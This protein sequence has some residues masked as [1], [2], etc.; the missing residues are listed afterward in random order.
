MFSRYQFH[1]LADACIEQKKTCTFLD[2]MRCCTSRSSAPDS[3]IP[4]SEAKLH[5]IVRFSNTVP[6]TKRPSKIAIKPS[7]RSGTSDPL[8]IKATGRGHTVF[9]VGPHDALR[10]VAVHGEGRF[11]PRLG[12]FPAKS[13][14]VTENSTSAVKNV[15]PMVALMCIQKERAYRA[16]KFD[17][18]TLPALGPG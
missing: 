14:C 2:E 10:R 3:R 6:C 9:H 17:A 1:D 18:V 15:S 12:R 7:A 5:I 11:C 8:L 4:H 16:D 13:M